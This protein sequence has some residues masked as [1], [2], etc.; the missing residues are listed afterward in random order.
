MRRRAFAV[1][2]LPLALSFFSCNGE[3]TGPDPREQFAGIWDLV[4]VNGQPVPAELRPGPP[5]RVE[6]L[7]IELD[8]PAT[9]AGIETRS[10][11]STPT[12]G[13]PTV[14]GGTTA[15]T[16]DISGNQVTIHNTG[17]GLPDDVGTL[18]DETLTIPRSLLGETRTHVYQKR[19]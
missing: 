12:G 5:V 10:F 9:G 3:G 6:V 7:S 19:P 17:S 2:V 8:L 13:A 11:R 4:S 15:V 1:A 18:D 16:F 14:T